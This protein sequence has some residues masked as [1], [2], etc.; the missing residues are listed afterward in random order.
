MQSFDSE[1]SVL[2]LQ[3]E[4][5]RTAAELETMSE[6]A[7]EKR[8]KYREQSEEFEPIL[9][10]YRTAAADAYLELMMQ[11]EEMIDVLAFQQWYRQKLDQDL[12]KLEQLHKE[13]VPLRNAVRT[14]QDYEALLGLIQSSMQKRQRL[15]QELK[16]ASEEEIEKA[17]SRLW[18]E[19]IGY[20][21][22]LKAD[23]DLIEADPTAF[24]RQRSSASPYRLEQDLINEKSKMRYY[25]RYDHIYAYFA[26]NDAEVILVGMIQ[27]KDGDLVA[28]EFE[29]GFVNGFQIPEELLGILKG[30]EIPYRSISNQASSDFFVESTTGAVIIQPLENMKE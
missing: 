11:G 7:E 30:F 21:L 2:A 16:G 10:F 4:L 19:N 3:E 6:E 23:K 5:K 27:R 25:F 9:K 24:I 13:Y 1:E 14:K 26:R 8:Q 20:L 18:T 15:Q 29:A 12:A 22:E 17:I 28:L